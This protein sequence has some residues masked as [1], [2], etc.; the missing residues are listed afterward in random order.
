MVGQIIGLPVDVVQRDGSA[1]AVR[2][3]Q[4][5][6]SPDW[7][8]DRRTMRRLAGSGG[9]ERNPLCRHPWTLGAE[10]YGHGLSRQRIQ[11]RGIRQTDNM[12]QFTGSLQSSLAV[13]R[14][15]VAG[16]R[17]PRTD[18]E[19]TGP[20]GGNGYGCRKRR[21]WELARLPVRESCNRL[22][23]YPGKADGRAQRISAELKSIHG[24]AASE[25]PGRGGMSLCGAG[26][27]WR[28]GFSVGDFA[29]DGATGHKAGAEST[30]N[31]A[32]R[33]QACGYGNAV[34]LNRD[35]RRSAFARQISG[36]VD[37]AIAEGRVA[38]QMLEC[39]GGIVVDKAAVGV[40]VHGRKRGKFGAMDAGGAQPGLHLGGFGGAVEMQFAGQ[41]AAPAGIGADDQPG[42]LAE[43]RLPPIQ[44]KVHRHLA[45]FGRTAHACLQPHHAGIGHVQAE[46]SAGRL[47]AQLKAPVPW[48]LLPKRE[49]SRDQRKRQLLHAALD[50]DAGV[51]GAKVGQRNRSRFAR[52]RCDLRGC[53]AEE[54]LQVPA[55]GIGA[56]QV[57]AGLV[58]ADAANLQPPAPQREQ[59]ER[60]DNRVGVENGLGA[61]GRIFLNGQVS[62]HKA[63]PGQQAQLH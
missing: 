13:H 51:G 33:I 28:S 48:L 63:R 61:V 55:A 50:I 45:Q 36:N 43:L 44:V 60:G 54:R 41:V 8:R 58:Y 37:A 9:A 2:A 32:Q 59:P 38:G 49:V 47:T 1:Q 57:Q 23:H 35:P 7:R 42:K 52:R 39:A 18:R 53:R 11:R 46:V 25:R 29:A 24:K 40:K 19:R 12:R 56:H 30:A 17:Q 14:D 20:V 5:G 3:R 27:A 15:L 4:S 10:V 6:L 31:G 21:R 62:E 22:Q 26:I 16:E 34:K